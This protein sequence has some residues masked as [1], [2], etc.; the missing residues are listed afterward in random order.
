VSDHIF[1][2]LTTV[3]AWRGKPTWYAVSRQDRTIAPPL[4]R[5]LAERMEAETMMVDGGHLALVSH[6]EEIADLI[7]RAATSLSEQAS[8]I[9]VPRGGPA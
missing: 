9:Q 1:G 4:Q 8:T 2:E 7:V 5:H 3:A 6:S